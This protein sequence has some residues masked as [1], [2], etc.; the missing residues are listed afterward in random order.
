MIRLAPSIL[1]ADFSRIGEAVRMTVKE[2]DIFFR[3]LRLTAFEKQVAEKLTLEMFRLGNGL[4]MEGE[5]RPL[6][7]PLGEFSV[8][9][10]AGGLL[11][12]FSLPKGSYATSVLREVMK[13]EGEV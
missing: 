11:L 4:D 3:S 13:G 9:A 2:A 12:S 1:S 7:V 10:D 8:S 5:R 6:R